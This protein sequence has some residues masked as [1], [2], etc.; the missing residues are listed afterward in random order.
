MPYNNRGNQAKAQWAPVPASASNFKIRAS[1]LFIVIMMVILSS[2]V[3]FCVSNYDTVEKVKELIDGGNMSCTWTNA[4][5][6]NETL[7]EIWCSVL[8][9]A[10]VNLLKIMHHVLIKIWK[11]FSL[12][13]KNT[14]ISSVMVTGLPMT[15]T[16]LKTW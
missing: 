4:G 1:F 3:K 15:C 8:Y 5:W 12:M 7:P 2:M 13:V 9:Y 10:V 11:S 16:S 6:S 14:P